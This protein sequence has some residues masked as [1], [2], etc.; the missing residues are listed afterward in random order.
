MPGA[1]AVTRQGPGDIVGEQTERDH[2][3]TPVRSAGVGAQQRLACES[4]PLGDPLRREIAGRREQ[5]D[6]LEAEAVKRPPAGKP[7]RPRRVA[8]ATRIG[9]EPVA[10][11]APEVLPGEP[12]D[13]HRPEQA[14]E[15]VAGDDRKRGGRAGAQGRAAL[16]Q[17]RLR[18]DLAV[19]LG[20]TRPAGDLRVLAGTDDRVDVIVT[21]RA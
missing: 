10:D 15:V 16:E 18:V 5:V 19:V 13:R 1:L 17:V 21:P 11:L 6:P 20:D 3:L 8:S 2:V 9:G 14:P 12:E 7:H 4:G